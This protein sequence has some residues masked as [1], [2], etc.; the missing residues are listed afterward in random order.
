M[1]HTL[2]LLIMLVCTIVGAGLLWRTSRIQ[3]A[4]WKWL[5][6]IGFGLLTVALALVT[7]L[8]YAGYSRLAGQPNPVSP[9]QVAA[10]PEQ[11][12]RG[13]SLV[14][15]CTRC[16]S[17]THDLP[18]DGGTVNFAPFL[19]GTL[20][21]PNLTPG[22]PLKGWTDGEII[23]AIREGVAQDGRALLVMPS[24]NFHQLSD[25]DVEAIVAYLRSQPAVDRSTGVN[26]LNV[27]GAAL[28]G[29]GLFRPSVQAPISAPVAAPAGV[30]PQ[31]GQYLVDVIGC[32]N[33]HGSDLAGGQPSGPNPDGPNLTTRVPQWSEADFIKTI[34]TGVDPTGYP[35]NSLMPWRDFAGFADDDLKA[36]YAYLHGL[37][38]IKR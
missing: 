30:T 4:V 20:Y 7:G 6:V 32:R 26:D 21:P 33:C 16:H 11:V 19:S 35:L 15:M 27:L 23:R 24:G 37:S 10:T 28:V 25:A 12:A 9:R 29:A 13:Q 5:G 38:P 3:N 36:I 2:S 31:Y 17:T 22:G 14:H 34:R 1:G 18:L 8:A